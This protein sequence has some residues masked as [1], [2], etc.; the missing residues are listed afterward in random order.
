MEEHKK[1]AHGD[2]H[3]S[4][5]NDPYFGKTEEEVKDYNLKLAE[6]RIRL[7]II[8]QYV[9]RTNNIKLKG[10]DFQQY[11]LKGETIWMYSSG[12]LVEEN[13]NGF[14]KYYKDMLKINNVPNQREQFES[15]MQ[16]YLQKGIQHLRNKKII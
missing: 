13:I 4:A 16:E 7:G 8:L 15:K 3:H 2:H 6:K 10:V 14:S 12:P 9:S 5:E 1:G 11:L